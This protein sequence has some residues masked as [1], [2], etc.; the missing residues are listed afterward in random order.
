MIINKKLTK[1]FTWYVNKELEATFTFIIYLKNFY[2]FKKPFI[3]LFLKGYFLN[4][5]RVGS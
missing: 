2:L 5:T 3:Y 1:F 4:H